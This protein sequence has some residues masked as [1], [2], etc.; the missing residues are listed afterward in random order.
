MNCFIYSIRST[1]AEQDIIN[2]RFRAKAIAYCQ[3]CNLEQHTRFKKADIA[4]RGHFFPNEP[5]PNYGAP[6][7]QSIGFVPMGSSPVV[8]SSQTVP[9][10]QQLSHSPAQHLHFSTV[11]QTSSTANGFAT[12]LATP[13]PT[14]G[15]P[16]GHKISSTFSGEP[17]PSLYSPTNSYSGSSFSSSPASDTLLLPSPT[18]GVLH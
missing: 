8:Q 9:S 14:Y 18:R 16:Y 12:T 15:D 2:K 13:S 10:Y 17:Q 7:T 3:T 5:I 11:P 1:S 4:F 6:A